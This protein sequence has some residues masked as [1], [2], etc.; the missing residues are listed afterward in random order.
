MATTDADLI[1]YYAD[2]LILQYKGKPKA[3]DTIKNL[4][5]PA[6]MNQIAFAVRDAFAIDTAVGVQL[7]VLAKYAGVSRLAKTFT[8]TIVLTDDELRFMIKMKIVQNNS[9]SS[10]Y[11]IQYLL[12]NY[13]DGALKVFDFKNMA[14]SYYFDSAFGSE[15]LAEAF[16]EQGLLPKPMGVQLASL[17]YIADLDNIFGFRTYDLPAVD[18]S[19]FNTYDDYETDRPWLSYANAIV[20]S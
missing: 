6:I 10:L 14:L 1:A 4:V 7:D 13:L 17:I 16:V 18:V 15:Q 20:T 19:G 5:T 2:L 11:D 3:Y 8:T 9:G 12:V